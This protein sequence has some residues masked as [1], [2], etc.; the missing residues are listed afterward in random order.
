[1]YL[2]SY[3]KI[4]T[5]PDLAGQ[6]NVHTPVCAVLGRKGKW[7]EFASFRCGGRS[8]VCPAPA[9]HCKRPCLAHS[10]GQAEQEARWGGGEVGRGGEGRGDRRADG[11]VKGGS[12]CIGVGAEAGAEGVC[13]GGGATQ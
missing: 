13:A 2:A 7:W 6:R 5:E 12:G 11:V 9:L 8:F 4:S 1:M 3:I 10:A